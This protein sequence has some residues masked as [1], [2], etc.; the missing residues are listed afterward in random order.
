MK[1]VRRFVQ[2]KRAITPVLS[3]LL[4]TVV[5][6]A[7]MSIATS[8]TFVITTNLRES[9]GERVMTEDVW[10]NNATGT[11]DVYVHNV[12]KMPIEVSAV[13][14]NHVRQPFDLPFRLGLNGHDWLRIDCSWNSGSVY[15]IDIVTSRGTHVA[16]YYKAP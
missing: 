6:V 13:Y 11:V 3:H 16:G 2:D 12:G 4:L 7:V 10:F 14:V 9:M 5:A 8:A 1:F 15:Y